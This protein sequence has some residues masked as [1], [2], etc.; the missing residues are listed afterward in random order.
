MG[1]KTYFEFSKNMMK[2][3]SDGQTYIIDPKGRSY[4]YSTS[5]AMNGP[6]FYDLWSTDGGTRQKDV[7]RWKTNW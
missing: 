2:Q 4:G 6:E 1:G 7:P 3:D 5:A